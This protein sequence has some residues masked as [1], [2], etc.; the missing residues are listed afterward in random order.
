M[1]RRASAKALSTCLLRRQLLY[2][3][4][5]AKRPNT[6]PVREA[7]FKTGG[8]DLRDIKGPRRQGRPRLEW[9]SEMKKC[10]ERVA[11]SK[12]NLLRMLRQAE[13][14]S[15]EWKHAVSKYTA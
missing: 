10:A 1:L 7:I 13:S 4:K 14:S 11:G 5:L 8:V 3:G 6:D 12:E 9:A 15:V 2:F